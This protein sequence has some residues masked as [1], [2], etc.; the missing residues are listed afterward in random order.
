MCLELICPPLC[1]FIWR[2]GQSW[3]QN[4]NLNNNVPTKSTVNKKDNI[5]N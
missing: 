2:H 1:T 4:I 5:H 3:K